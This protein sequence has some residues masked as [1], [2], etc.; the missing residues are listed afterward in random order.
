MLMIALGSQIAASMVKL[1][2]SV[3]NQEEEKHRDFLMVFRA[4][5]LVLIIVTA[6]YSLVK[7]TTYQ[8]VM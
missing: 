4:G 5:S 7:D 1:G 8:A 2:I 3:K 6:V